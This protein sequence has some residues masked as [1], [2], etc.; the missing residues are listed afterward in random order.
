MYNRYREPSIDV[1]FQF[2]VNFG[3]GVSEENIV[4]FVFFCYKLTNQKHRNKNCPW[5]PWL[6]TDRDEIR[7]RYRGSAVDSSYQ[8]LIHLAK[9][10]QRKRFICYVNGRYTMAEGR[11]VMVKTYFA[12]GKVS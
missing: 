4:F 3:Q 5:Q 7:N 6:S 12:F 8:V 1:S 11:Q 9:R 10:F 2:L